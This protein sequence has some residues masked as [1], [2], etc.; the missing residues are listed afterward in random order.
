MKKIVDFSKFLLSNSKIITAPKGFCASAVK[1]GIKRG[2]LFDLGLLLS[3]NETFVTAVFTKNKMMAAPV[4]FCKQLLTEKTM[5][6]GIIVNSGNANAGTGKTGFDDCIEIV[7][8][9]EHKLNLPEHSILIAS[10]GVI[11]Q[12]LPKNKFFQSY[13]LLI[14]Q[15]SEDDNNFP[16]AIKTT[17]R[18]TKAYGL[19]IQ[20]D[21]NRTFSI[22]AVAKG[23]GMICPNMAT[24]L[25]FITTD[26]GGDKQFFKASLSWVV[27][28]TFNR[29]TVDGDMSTN[30]SVFLFANGESQVFLNTQ[31]EK[32]L[33]KMALLYLCKKLAID[34]VSDGE[35]AKKCVKII[36][37]GAKNNREAKIGAF[38]ISNSML[39]KTM[40]GGEDPN[41]GRIIAAIGASQ[42]NAKEENINILFNEFQLVK[43]GMYTSQTI[44]EKIAD[45]M[46]M[47]NYEITIDLNLGKGSYFVYTCDIGHTYIDINGGYRS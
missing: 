37:K 45:L 14:S 46:K 4:L 10:T 27:N 36:V 9:L 38:K 39:V 32:N 30:D 16:E 1:A 41:W 2:T 26:V 29:I 23:A 15:L 47:K 44:E 11:G 7:K 40:I 3:K 31:Y 18:Y 13:P 22:G 43:N 20:L 12:Y 21:N 6:R 8:N 28:Q 35:G 19:K 34:I 25:A 24:M 17:D 5:F 42:I 33:F